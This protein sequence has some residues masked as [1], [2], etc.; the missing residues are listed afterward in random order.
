MKKLICNCT[1]NKHKRGYFIRPPNKISIFIYAYRIAVDFEPPD[2]AADG[3]SSH[4]RSEFQFSLQK[5]GNK[6][7]SKTFSAVTFLETCA[8]DAGIS[9]SLF[10]FLIFFFS[11]SFVGA[12]LLA[13]RFFQNEKTPKKNVV[14]MNLIS[15]CKTNEAMRDERT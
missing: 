5:K 11:K 12:H 6:I 15:E 8:S 2:D 1:H 7:N 10:F 3:L 9:F 13:F 14:R 4:K